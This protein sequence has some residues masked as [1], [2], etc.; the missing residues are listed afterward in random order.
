MRQFIFDSSGSSF[1]AH[2]SV[3]PRSNPHRKES[4]RSPPLSL[5]TSRSL[6]AF[7]YRII[8]R[9]ASFGPRRT[10]SCVAH[11]L[12]N[13]ARAL[14]SLCFQLCFTSLSVSFAV[15]CTSPPPLL[16]V[17]VLHTL[18]QRLVQARGVL[19]EYVA[20][21]NNDASLGGQSA[22]LVPSRSTHSAPGLS[23]TIPHATQPT[24]LSHFHFP[25]FPLSS[26][27]AVP[28]LHTPSFRK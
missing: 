24:T 7:Q 5:C 4:R 28:L 16:R 3:H 1:L 26:R 18:P 23:T 17:S 22:V 6:C 14:L 15:S 20:H 9:D 13:T 21:Q 2:S 10:S 8:F 25:P 27:L 12:K 19:F 11:H